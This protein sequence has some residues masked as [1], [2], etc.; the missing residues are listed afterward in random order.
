VARVAAEAVGQTTEQTP[1]DSILQAPSI[2]SIQTSGGSLTVDRIQANLSLVKTDGAVFTLG[3]RVAIQANLRAREILSETCIKETNA[4]SLKY[5][6]DWLGGFIGYPAEPSR[7][8]VVAPNMG[9]IYGGRGVSGIFVAGSRKDGTPDYSGAIRR[10]STI[11]GTGQFWGEA[12]CKIVYQ[13][14]PNQG[15]D[16]TV[17]T[18]KP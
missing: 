16:F 3:S 4:Q 18:H 6:S 9:P 13:F 11:A 10:F 5:N 17:Y 14:I 12:H 8:K 1:Q 7:M 2:Y 15:T